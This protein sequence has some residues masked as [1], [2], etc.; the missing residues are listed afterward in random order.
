[1]ETKSGRKIE[2]ESRKEKKNTEYKTGKLK[3]TCK[4]TYAPVP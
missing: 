4:K 3:N 1:M 2:D